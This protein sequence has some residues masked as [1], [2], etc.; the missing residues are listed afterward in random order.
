VRLL[1]AYLRDERPAGCA[2]AQC[3]VVLRGPSAGGPLTEAGMRSVFRTHRARSGAL[4][5]RPHRLR[6]SYG[7][8][9]AAAGIDLLVLQ[10]LPIAPLGQ[11]ML[12][13]RVQ[14]LRTEMLK[15][16]VAH[17]YCSRNLVAEAC[18]YA[19]ICEQCDNF[20][21]SVEFAPTLQS[22][23]ADVTALREDAEAR[24]WDTEV[25]RHARVLHSLTRQLDRLAHSTSPSTTT[26]HQS[27]SRLIEIFFGI[28]TRQAI[29]CGTFTSVKQLISAIE[30]FIDGWNDRSTPF[31]WTKSADDILTKAHRQTT[32]NTRH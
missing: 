6:H 21:T 13:D 22:Q 12:T 23:L 4:R 5:V 26:S 18:S 17:G 16:R 9:L 15:T 2:T 1:A 10:D 19:N 24:G 31:I 20:A 30:T 7:T 28:I 14:W 3:F 25:A 11:A 27:Q 32:S 8:E 29:R